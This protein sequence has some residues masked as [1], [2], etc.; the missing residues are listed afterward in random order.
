M[1]FCRLKLSFRLLCALGTAVAIACAPVRAQTISESFTGNTASGWVMTGVG[2]TPVL[3]SG[4]TD[5]SGN[6]WLRL[7]DTSTY[8]ATSAYYNTAFTAANATVY[9]SFNFASYGGS[10]GTT[11]G[12]D[13]IVFFLF[14]GASTFNVGADGGSIGYAQK[15]AVAG[16]SGGY[17][18]VALDEYGNFSAASEGR[19]GGY[20]GSTA[21]ITES[22][23]VRGPG[24][25]TT[26]YAYL[27]GSGTLAT[28]LDS[29]TRPTNYTVQILLSP[30]NQLTV[31]LQQG[32]TSPQTVLQM[33]LSGYARPD[34]L[35]LGFSSGSGSATNIH[36]V[37]NVQ[38]TT[39]VANLWSNIGADSSWTTGAN[40]DP[41]SIVPPAGS[42]ILFDNTFIST[43]QTI[44]TNGNQSVRSLQF[45][46]P[47]NYTISSG[48]T[49]TVNNQ[50]VP[51]FS[52]VS[53]SQTHGTSTT[54]IGSNLTFANDGFIRNNS[55]GALSITG[56]IANG[57]YA[58]TVD[59]TGSN[60]TLSGIISGTGGLTKNDSGTFTLSGANTYSGNTTLN[61]GV[62]NANSSTAVGNGTVTLAGGTLGST[63]GSSISNAL[64]L[65]ANSGLSGLTTTGAMTQT[66][67]STLV[68][69][70]AT[71]S[72]NVALSNSGTNRTLTTQVDAGTST[73]SGIIS[74]GGTATSG[75]LTKTGSGEL[76]LSGANTYTGTT[77]ISNGTLTIGAAGALADTSSLNIGSSGT[78]NL[79]T[80]SEKVGPLAATGGATID[81]GTTGSANNFVFGNYTPPASGVL[82]INNFE[83]GVDKLA[84]TQ[85]GIS[86]A[87]LGTIYISGI[88][89]V[90][91][92]AGA[93]S[94]IGS[95]GNAYLLTATP[96]TGVVWNGAGS[97]WNTGA[98]WVGGT[99]PGTTQVAVF[100]STGAANLTSV[101]GS[102]RTIRGIMF[103]TSAPGYTVSAGGGTM[104]LSG[105]VPY[106]QQ[107]SSSNQAVNAPITLAASSVMDIT[108]SGNLT[109][110][111]NVAGTG[112]SLIKDGTGTGKL[113]LSGANTFTGGTFVNTGTVQAQST[114]ALGTG[115]ATIANGGALAL[116]GG[117]S[118]TNA[119]SVVGSG[120]SGGGAISNVSGTNTL[121]GVITMVGDTLITAATGTTLNLT[122][123]ATGLTGAGNDV[124]FS[125]TGTG[126]IN[127]NRLVNGSGTVTVTG[128][129]VNFNG[130]TNAN[131]Y[132]G[133]TIV[134]GGTLTLTKTAGTTAIAGDVSLTGGT[135]TLGA[136]N[137]IADTSAVSLSG[138]SVFNVS[139]RAET[140]GAISSASSASSI[141]L[142]TGGALTISGPNNAT[143]SF[144]GALTGT[145]TSSLNLTGTG[146]TYLSGNNSGFLGTTN[147]TNGTLNVSGSNTVLGGTGATVA[148]SS[149]GNLQL[150][151][152]I[153]VSNAVSINGTGTTTNGAIENFTGN[154]TMSG[155]ITATGASRIN[156][157]S[158]TLTLSGALAPSANSLTFGG[159]AN[160]SLTGTMNGSGGFTKDGTG[161][162]TL[163]SGFVS[164]NTGAVA[165]TQGSVS[166]LS[167][168]AFNSS[169]A[170]TMS[171][172]SSLSLNNLSHTIAN[173]NGAGTVD[174]GSSGALTL[175]SGTSL[176]SG[177]FSGAGT[178]TLGAG[179]TFTLGA[180]FN[181]PNLNII[182]AGGTLN[183]NGYTGTFG[184]L[185]V[186]GT[187]TINFGAAQASTLTV[188]GVSFTGAQ[189]LNVTNWTDMTDYFYSSTSP[190][191]QG[192]AP[193]NQIV[194]SGFSGN[195]THWNSYD[196]QITP[197]PEPRTYGMLLMSACL[198]IIG[199]HRWRKNAKNAVP[200]SPLEP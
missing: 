81:F 178:L 158:G 66:A 61:A 77:T 88:G 164:T 153:S 100:D 177:S 90:T 95:L 147:I 15:T 184:N 142:G 19:V 170:L 112:F 59:G 182:L 17:L 175:S 71:Q 96:A 148:V 136:S 31:T 42:D 11:N 55:T 30:T 68:L 138:S 146:K 111:G 120:V 37:R 65:S 34:T 141:T 151:G 60:S 121:S 193:T 104:T 13:G 162:L 176:F 87:N 155:T 160:I 40:W 187:S 3:T 191:T 32:G 84:S 73:I 135:L 50:G 44:A 58:L 180:G 127:V 27:G 179:S 82:V 123:T 133:D 35:K 198:T 166:A 24:S 140:V 41:G 114:T 4:V 49:I 1:D 74:N 33:D 197:V 196:H 28:A 122:N 6:G 79:N 144:A 199:Y 169:N 116:S 16:L 124:T 149:A 119:V 145:A 150:Q 163:G 118:P 101:F 109:L 157:D 98:N 154:N 106:I 171:A 195:A 46:S 99:R 72:G 26:G 139:G 18:G 69:S 78:L 80:F 168:T 63:N 53:V 38:L 159:D 39:V 51:G 183:L 125:P 93:L 89:V 115:T 126:I 132:T 108:G 113:I 22:V 105:S 190:G 56:A 36:E 23:G 188:N 152:G 62:L 75:N 181:S 103:D 45:D 194:F 174:F 29:A 192:A 57:G 156:S 173:L 10:G 7:T 8:T 200:A 86:T 129:N 47:H 165:I 134:S 5:P 143:S 43:A 189:T 172:G 48:N 186:S 52:G 67:N 110:G 64:T 107:K 161:S 83:S 131:T 185:T 25:G 9:A 70:S 130:T 20:N 117:I 21:A 137:Q 54:T 167:T 2:Y 76:I 12:G 91:S 102:N 97:A 92:E 85:A 128:G 94:A 14:D